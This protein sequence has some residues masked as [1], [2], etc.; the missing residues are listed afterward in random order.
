MEK[1]K[2]EEKT[3]LESDRYGLDQR[4]GYFLF[5]YATYTTRP[6]RDAMWEL[7]EAHNF[8]SDTTEDELRRILASSELEIPK[9][10]TV[11]VLEP[12]GKVRWVSAAEGALVYYQYALAEDLRSLYSNIESAHVG[13]VADN[14]LF[15]FE[16][17]FADHTL[18]RMLNHRGSPLPPSEVMALK[19]ANDENGGDETDFLVTLHVAVA[20][21]VSASSSVPPLCALASLYPRGDETFHRRLGQAVLAEPEFTSLL[22]GDRDFRSWEDIDDFIVSDDR[23]RSFVLVC[24]TTDMVKAT[25]TILHEHCF[26]NM[27]SVLRHLSLLSE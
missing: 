11:P 24:T 21:A 9:E 23:L 15:R 12:G 6:W 27:T 7:R 10:R 1:V 22:P 13:L 17:S 16:Q 19:K 8:T 20:M 4:Y 18:N 5:L 2:N 26:K 25:D 3:K 14:H